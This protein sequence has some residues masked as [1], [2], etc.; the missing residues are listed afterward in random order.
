LK[1][2]RARWASHLLTIY[3]KRIRMRISAHFNRSKRNKMDFKRRF[4]TVD[5]TRIH[6]CEHQ[7]EK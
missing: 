5:E 3:Q 6:H 4:T 2:L 7:C 1:K